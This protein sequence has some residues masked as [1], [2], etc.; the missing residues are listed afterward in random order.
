[1]DDLKVLK[2]ASAVTLLFNFMSHHFDKIPKEMLK[3]VFR[4]AFE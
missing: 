2:N 1:M 3:D 4:L